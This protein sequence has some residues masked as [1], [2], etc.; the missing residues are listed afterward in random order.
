MQTGLPVIN[1]LEKKPDVPF[2]EIYDAQ[3]DQDLLRIA[4][5]L[6]EQNTRVMAGCAGLAAV[7]PAVLGM[8]IGTPPDANAPEKLLVLCASM[9]P[10]TRAQLK[11]AAKEG[12]CHVRL[13]LAVKLGTPESAAERHDLVLNILTRCR[14]ELPVMVDSNDANGETLRYANANAITHAQVRNAVARAMG[15]IGMELVTAGVNSTLLITGGDTLMGF[16]AAAGT[17]ELSPVAEIF[18]GVVLSWLET[19]KKRVYVIF[20]A[21]SFGDSRLLISVA[22]SLKGDKP[23]L[24]RSGGVG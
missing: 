24:A 15:T 4:H 13:P 19:G 16:L 6:R 7:M 11:H 9:H 3:T 1:H 8:P 14:Q 2:W 10:A 5:K 17:S 23:R 18:P 22:Q 12:F 20:K 21:G